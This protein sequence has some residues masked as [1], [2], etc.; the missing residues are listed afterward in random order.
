VTRILAEPGPDYAAG[1]AGVAMK[2]PPKGRANRFWSFLLRRR[3]RFAA[4]YLFFTVDAQ[5]DGRWHCRT[6]QPAGGSGPPKVRDR[7]DFYVELPESK[8]EL[9]HP[10]PKP[11]LGTLPWAVTLDDGT[12]VEFIGVCANSGSTWWGPDGSALAYWPGFLGQERQSRMMSELIASRA[13]RRGPVHSR[14]SER[15]DAGIAVVLRVPS[16]AGPARGSGRSSSHSSS[17]ST[18]VHYG[19]RSPLLDRFGLPHSPGQYIVLKFNRGDQPSINHALGIHVGAAQTRPETIRL[20]RPRSRMRGRM[21]GSAEHRGPQARLSPFNGAQPEADTDLPLQWV[22][23]K[24]IS[25]HSGQ[26]TEFEMVVA[27]DAGDI[28][29]TSQ[30]QVRP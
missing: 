10:R 5:A 2:P 20:G 12:P 16:L 6:T 24:N 3:R 21:M 1:L 9:T 8:L 28:D 11:E 25:P 29:S 27:E 30:V 19:D 18:S 13:G 22:Q 23:L 14:S 15:D 4:P 7:F 17:G 26:H